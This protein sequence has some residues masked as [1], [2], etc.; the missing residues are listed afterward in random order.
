MEVNCGRILYFGTGLGGGVLKLKASGLRVILYV[1]GPMW[2]NA[3]AARSMSCSAN[4]AAQAVGAELNP[5][6]LSSKM[7]CRLPI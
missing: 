6:D 2:F 3:S 5:F 7:L 1:S 4:L